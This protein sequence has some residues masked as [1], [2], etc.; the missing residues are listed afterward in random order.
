MPSAPYM[1][2]PPTYLF[3]DSVDPRNRRKVLTDMGVKCATTAHRST[4]RLERREFESDGAGA[5]SATRGFDQ[6]EEVVQW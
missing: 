5:R 1:S 4:A 2:G 6:E 3:S